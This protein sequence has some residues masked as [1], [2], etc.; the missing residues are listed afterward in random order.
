MTD[1]KHGEFSSKEHPGWRLE[2]CYP[3]AN[4]DAGFLIV[5]FFFLML[6]WGGSITF[7]IDVFIDLHSNLHYA[8]RPSL[9]LAQNKLWNTWK[10]LFDQQHRP[11]RKKTWVG[12][13][14]MF[15]ITHKWWPK[16]KVK[17]FRAMTGGVTLFIYP[18]P[19]EGLSTTSP[20]S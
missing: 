16:T 17:T 14:M 13:I 10:N 6:G 1:W 20:A 3:A 19:T 9:V 12:L 2:K 11:Q 7:F 18:D 4:N 5:F 8:T 15:M